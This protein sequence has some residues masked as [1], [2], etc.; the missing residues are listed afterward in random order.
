MVFSTNQVIQFYDLTKTV[1]SAAA[2]SVAVETVDAQSKKR[3]VKLIVDGTESRSPMFDTVLSVTNTAAEGDVLKRKIFKVSV[4]TG[5]AQP[6]ETYDLTIMYRSAV[7]EED[8]YHKFGSYIAK[9]GD[10]E[11]AIL[12]GLAESLRINAKTEVSPLYKLYNAAGTEITTAALAAAVTGSFYIVEPVPDWELG[13]FPE[14]L[15][16]MTVEG[17]HINDANGVEREWATIEKYE[18]GATGLP[19]FAPAVDPIYNAHTVADLEYFAMGERGNSNWQ[20]GWPENIKPKKKVD[21][22]APYGYDLLVAH[23]ANTGYNQNST[24]QEFDL[25]FAEKSA[26]GKTEST[27]LGALETDLLA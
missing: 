15:E 17:N 19:T 23:V 12:K 16:N 27:L 2:S 4:Q 25:I 7:G 9:T 10:D 14:T 24:L 18:A 20:F 26:D 3:V 8:T 11:A 1:A 5:A 6:G 21:A 13:S 22:D